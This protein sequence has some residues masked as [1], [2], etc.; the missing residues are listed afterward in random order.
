MLCANL[1]NLVPMNDSLRLYVVF[2]TAKFSSETFTCVCARKKRGVG[3]MYGSWPL[4]NRD[5]SGTALDESCR[6]DD[7]S[8]MTHDTSGMTRDESVCAAAAMSAKNAACCHRK[9]LSAWTVN[10]ACAVLPVTLGS[11]AK[12]SSY[13]KK[14]RTPKISVSCWSVSCDNS[15]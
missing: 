1:K 12:S 10:D 14:S 9:L 7:E 2:T 8:V 13:V 15:V 6:P 3:R 11:D 5:V 4:P